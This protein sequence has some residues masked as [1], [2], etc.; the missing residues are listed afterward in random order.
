VTGAMTPTD[1]GRLVTNIVF[2]GMGEPLYNLEAVKAA[3]EVISDG[4]GLTLSRRRI[5]V[6]TSGVVPQIARL[7]AEVAPMLAISLHAVRDELRDKLVPLNRVAGGVPHLSRPVQCPPHHLRI[8]D[9]EGGERQPGR[10]ARTGAPTE[11][12]PG[13]DQPDPAQSMAGQPL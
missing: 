8:C 5:T 13:E 2:M 9:A 6:S 3:I 10:G 12:H 1:G 7:G 11:E 4:E